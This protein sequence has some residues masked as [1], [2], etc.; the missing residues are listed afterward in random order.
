MIRTPNVRFAIGMIVRR[1][2]HPMRYVIHDWYYT[3]EMNAEWQIKNRIYD[4][5]YKAEQPFYYVLGENGCV[6]HLPQGK[7]LHKYKYNTVNLI[8]VLSLN[9]SLQK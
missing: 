5:E 1:R 9:L 6:C 4:L 8:H 3:C 7:L 2:F